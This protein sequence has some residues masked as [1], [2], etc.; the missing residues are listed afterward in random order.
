MHLLGCGNIGLLFAHALQRSGV[1]VSLL[2]RQGSAAASVAV[3]VTH[4]SLSSKTPN[5]TLSKSPR[6]SLAATTRTPNPTQTT[7]APQTTT[8][9][10]A[11]CHA[12]PHISTLLVCTKA[13]DTRAALAPLFKSRTLTHDSTVVLLQNGVLAV[14][15]EILHFLKTEQIE[16]TPRFV[17][18]STTHG[19]FR[20][21]Q[22]PFHVNHVGY[23]DAVFGEP[24]S[25]NHTAPN[26]VFSTLAMARDLNVQC[27]L[28]WESLHH[29][30]MTK[31]AIN[32]VLNPLTAVFNCRNGSIASLKQGRVLVDALCDELALLPEF[33][34]LLG[35]LPP[36]DGGA[37]FSAMVR[38]VAE[39][40][41]LNVNSMDADVSRGVETEIAY[42]NGYVLQLAKEHGIALP[43]H[44]L[45]VKMVAMKLASVQHSRTK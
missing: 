9:T 17:L 25:S 7:D 5:P 30:L 33:Y 4:P 27:P 41:R 29:K 18:G 11:A 10:H 14:H 20:D 21:P 1:P 32:S 31:L 22:D 8:T 44:E 15:D 34:R 39:A 24:P 3:R 26:P 19:A 45:V 42:L 12:P 2:L 6:P 40:T 37:E 43:N 35:P 36:L 28:P 38:T 23:G 16:S 13:K